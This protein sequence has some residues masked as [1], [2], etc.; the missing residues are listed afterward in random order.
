ME[1]TPAS[2]GKL[3]AQLE[4]WGTKLDDLV[5]KAADLDE[6]AKHESLE[7]INALEAKHTLARAKLDEI[8]VV[9]SG[10]WKRF[11]DGIEGAWGELESALGKLEG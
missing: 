6:A 11:E 9:G 4:Q 8:S 2:I 5:A 1:R 7:R 3:R 10:K